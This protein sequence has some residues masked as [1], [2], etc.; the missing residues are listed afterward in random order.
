METLHEMK[1]GTELSHTLIFYLLSEN[2]IMT[3]HS[4]IL[5]D[6]NQSSVQ[7]NLHSIYLVGKVKLVSVTHNNSDD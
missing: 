5:N 6:V 4:V 1:H 2:N 3:V 7:S